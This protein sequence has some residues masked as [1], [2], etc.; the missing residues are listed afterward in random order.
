M[1]TTGRVFADPR[2]SAFI[3]GYGIC[4]I[5]PVTALFVFS[6]TGSLYFANPF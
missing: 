6:S 4:R 5:E 3:R 1:T 2:K